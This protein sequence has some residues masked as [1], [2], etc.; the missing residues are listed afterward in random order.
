MILV[1]ILVVWLHLSVFVMLVALSVRLFLVLMMRLWQLGNVWP[2]QAD[3]RWCEFQ[4]KVRLAR[5]FYAYNL[6]QVGYLGAPVLCFGLV[7]PAEQVG[8][9]SAALVI[10][11]LFLQ[12][13]YAS[14]GALLPLLTRLYENKRTEQL[15]EL[16]QR[17]LDILIFVSVPIAV[18]LAIF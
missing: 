12:W 11:D 9:F 2:T 8:W 6:T 7:A 1:T 18:L 13:S 15:L 16:R 5:P 3:W 14:T 4:R 10:S 17:L